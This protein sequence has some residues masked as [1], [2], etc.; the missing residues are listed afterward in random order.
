[1]YTQALEPHPQP[2][3]GLLPA[4]V[5]SCAGAEVRGEE[6]NS[7]STS[8]LQKI[9]LQKQKTPQ[10]QLSICLL[11]ISHFTKVLPRDKSRGILCANCCICNLYRYKDICLLPKREKMVQNQNQNQKDALTYN[12]LLLLYYFLKCLNS[13]RAKEKLL[14]RENLITKK[15]PFILSF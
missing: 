13:S 12:K 8:A 1:M 15:A 6:L 5:A 10:Q 4:E 11:Q 2:P 9:P 3:S 7:G 14:C